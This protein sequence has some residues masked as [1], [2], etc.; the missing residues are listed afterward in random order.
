MGCG[1]STVGRALADHIGW[2]FADLD[3]DIEKANGIPISQIFAEQGEAQFRAHETAA[4]R[5]R[6]RMIQSGRPHVLALGGGAFTQA[7]N[8][9]SIADHGVSI[10]LDCPL[11]VIEARVARETHRPL[12]RDLDKM[13]ELFVSRLPSYA[14]ADYRIEASNDNPQEAVDRILALD[15]L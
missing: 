14:K 3:D 12:A 10:W 9:A 5:A 2:N 15:L 1:K 7:T 8:Q 4:L 6:I 11:E 13:R